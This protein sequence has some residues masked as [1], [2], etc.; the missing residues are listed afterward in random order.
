MGDYPERYPVYGAVDEDQQWVIDQHLVDAEAAGINVFAVNWYRDD[1]LS[2]AADRMAA[3][4]SAS[5]VK[6]CIQWS[7]HYTRMSLTYAIKSYLFEGIRRAAL[8]M[9]GARYWMK[10]SKPVFILFSA[11][12]LDDVIRNTTANDI[13]YTPTLSEKN[14][15]IADIRNIIGNVLDGDTTGGISGSTV[16]ASVNPGPYLVLMT[17]LAEWYPVTGV[18]AYTTYNVIQGVFG[19]TVR[20]S[21]SYP[22]LCQAVE[23]DWPKNYSAL[24]TYGKKRWPLMTAGCSHLPWGGIDADP[25]ADYSLPTPGEFRQHA[26]NTRQF[27]QDPSADLTVFLY[28]WN[29]LG[30]GAWVIPTV[31]RGRTMVNVL[32]EAML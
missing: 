31:G 4:A 9:N 24:R 28:A 13:N 10:D 12:H 14:A 19:G 3:S 32:T 2:Y 22:E 25:L 27:A 17:D 6:W 1:Y 8:R 5:S 21:H 20:Y 29:E 15:L 11:E 26:I 16:S 23:Q 30:E 18:D 7:N